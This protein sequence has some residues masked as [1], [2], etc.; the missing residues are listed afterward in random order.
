M[1]NEGWGKEGERGGLSTYRLDPGASAVCICLLCF[2]GALV[3]VEHP[4][5]HLATRPAQSRLREH[6]DGAAPT[7]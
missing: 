2:V 6:H 3:S 5:N 7:H 4:G 1:V